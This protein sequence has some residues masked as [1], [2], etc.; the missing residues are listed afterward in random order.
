MKISREKYEIDGKWYEGPVVQMGSYRYIGEAGQQI[1]VSFL[2]IGGSLFM[3]GLL[4]L[5]LWGLGV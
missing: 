1:A 3:I 5:L 4:F 2:V